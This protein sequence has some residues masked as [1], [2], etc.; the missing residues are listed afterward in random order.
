MSISQA[1]HFGI[2]NRP[3]CTVCKRLMDVSRRS[4]HPL[5]GNAYELQTFEC[6]TCR[7]EIERTSDGN[8]LPHGSEAA[9]NG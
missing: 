4:P 2:N 7:R 9:P 8:G 1:R 5:H 6:P 3:L